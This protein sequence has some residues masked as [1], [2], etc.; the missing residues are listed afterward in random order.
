MRVANLE[1]EL[2][3]FRRKESE[4]RASPPP[5]P[6]PSSPE[7]KTKNTMVLKQPKTTRQDRPNVLKECRDWETN[8]PLWCNS[9][10][11]KNLLKKSIIDTSRGSKKVSYSLRARIS[12]S[13]GE[14]Y[15]NYNSNLRGYLYKYF[16]MT[17]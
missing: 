6:E 11:E 12:L 5:I 4:A 13:D 14:N 1:K 2:A 16:V 9:D 3:K 7:E 8:F 10:W 17:L 15:I